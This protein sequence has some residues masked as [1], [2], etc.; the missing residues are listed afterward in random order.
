MI[1]QCDQCKTRFRLDDSR[2]TVSGVRVRC[3]RC[4]HTF[5]VKKENDEEE[6]DVRKFMQELESS[7]AE[8]QFPDDESD[9]NLMGY[10]AG[11]RR[12]S[13]ENR[14]KDDSLES[15]GNVVSH[16]AVSE[17]RS[18]AGLSFHSKED[19]P[20]PL[21]AES[22]KDVPEGLSDAQR[23]QGDFDEVHNARM[24]EGYG[25]GRAEQGVNEGGSPDGYH[26]RSGDQDNSDVG[27]RTSESPSAGEFEI[28]YPFDSRS[29]ENEGQ[30]WE[31]FPSAGEEGE[32]DQ[33]A[34]K[35][36]VLFAGDEQDIA[37][38]QDFHAENYASGPAADNIPSGS[39]GQI[40][41]EGIS[42]KDTETKHKE[43]GI[44]EVLGFST[45][46]PDKPVSRQS[47]V[48]REPDD[49][50]LPPLA[51][52]SRRKRS[53]PAVFAGVLLVLF[54]VAISA[55][56][57]WG[58]ESATAKI[59]GEG[60]VAGSASSEQN[61]P[62]EIAIKNL[63]GAF[64]RNNTDGEIFI[65]RG[66]AFNASPQIRTSVNVQGYIYGEKGEVL[67]NKAAYF[68]K[69]LTDEQAANLP[70]N[71]L[72]SFLQ[73]KA[74]DSAQAAVVQPDMG[75]PFVIIFRNVP[76]NAGEFGAEAVG[77]TAP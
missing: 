41:E 40:D 27:F 76:P 17:A 3:S 60:V 64:V 2:V 68:G 37:R 75:I 28:G 8:R 1:I 49:E 15:G 29:R 34:M 62:T 58:K 16:D 31:I 39:H 19:D 5:I 71:E 73:S 47:A 77:A 63:E 18:E 45:D 20:G 21:H 32:K 9:E 69:N 56:Y 42:E 14:L 52:T 10:E 11:V 53:F 43:R 67:M 4:K 51:I 54:L 65:V 59:Q 55:Y 35:D 74:G 12:E 50:E 72:E 33:R 13:D 36:A 6:A 70:L 22:V 25:A 23:D 61:L 7:S 46:D 66:E 30:S 24:S 38:E 57:F 44:R 26:D 48:A